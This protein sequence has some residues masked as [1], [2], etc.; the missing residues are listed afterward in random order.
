[1]RVAD[2]IAQAFRD[3]RRGLQ[4]SM[5]DVEARTCAL[6]LEYPDLYAG[7]NRNMVSQLEAQGNP[8][9]QVMD[10]RSQRAIMTVIF[11]SV[12]AFVEATGTDLHLSG[13]GRGAQRPLIPVFNEADL[14]TPHEMLD[15]ESTSRVVS[16]VIGAR[17]AVRVATDKHMPMLYP[18]QLVYAQPSAAQAIGTLC[19]LHHHG[20]IALG[21]AL[22]NDRF[23]TPNGPVVSLKNSGHAIG[24]VIGMEPGI[25]PQLLAAPGSSEEPQR[26]AG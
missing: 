17:Y 20:R 11:G 3:R 14:V 4:Y 16:P 23:A 25:P 26:A 7:V 13:A 22:G 9:L 2:E 19:V 1:M 8:R 6:A 5:R 10:H 12:E 24:H 21:Y 15:Y 18:G